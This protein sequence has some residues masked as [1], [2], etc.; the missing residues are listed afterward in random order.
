MTKEELI[1]LIDGMGCDWFKVDI[2][3]QS[4]PRIT[5]TVDIRRGPIYPPQPFTSKTIVG[6]ESFEFNVSGYV[7]QQKG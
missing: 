2:K 1:N 6:V 5:E 3:L 7:N 4:P